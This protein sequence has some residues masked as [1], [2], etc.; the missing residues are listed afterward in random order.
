LEFLEKVLGPALLQPNASNEVFITAF[1]SKCLKQVSAPALLTGKHQK[2][3]KDRIV[4]VQNG[5][6][7]V[8][9]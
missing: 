6:Y 8:Q 7:E 2:N 1:I 4:C 9:G 3:M 5:I